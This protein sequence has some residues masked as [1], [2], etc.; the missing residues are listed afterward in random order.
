M[1]AFK[2]LL[3]AGEFYGDEK[4][5]SELIDAL[6][7]RDRL[8]LHTHFISDKE[9]PDYFCAADVVVQPYRNATQSGVTPLA[10]HFERPMIVTNVGGLPDMVPHEK[11]GLVTSPDPTSIT[12]TIL[13]F[14]Q[15][16]EDYFIPHLREEK[17]KY[18]WP[19]FIQQIHNLADSIQV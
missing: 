1:S 13:W 5:Y 17:V 7:I 14:Y 10:Y 19:N 4:W 15:Y 11:V 18:S 2:E 9:V 8:Y 6:G 12:E 3:I 16:G